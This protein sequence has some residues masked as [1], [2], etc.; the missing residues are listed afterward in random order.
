MER[1]PLGPVICGLYRQ[2]VII[3]KWSLCLTVMLYSGTF[4]LRP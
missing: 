1:V 3:Y 2:V 4:K